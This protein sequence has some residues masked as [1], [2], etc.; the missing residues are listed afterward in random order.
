MQKYRKKKEK[1]NK[2]STENGLARI[3]KVEEEF[4][5]SLFL[6]RFFFTPFVYA[7]EIYFVYLFIFRLFFVL[8]IFVVVF[9]C[10][11]V[12]ISH[13]CHI[14]TIKIICYRTF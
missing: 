5:A 11:S 9:G 14:K 4:N 1:K 7:N 8:K 12:T 2:Y 10:I 3:D 6:F 13:T